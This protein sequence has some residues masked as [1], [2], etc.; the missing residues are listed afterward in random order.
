LVFVLGMRLGSGPLVVV[1]MFGMESLVVASLLDILHLVLNT[2]VG[3]V[4]A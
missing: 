4:V 2:M 3:G 1:Q